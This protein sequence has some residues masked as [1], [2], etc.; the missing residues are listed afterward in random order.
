M[1]KKQIVAAAVR[2]ELWTQ[3]RVRDKLAHKGAH[4]ENKSP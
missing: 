2:R 3:R 4:K 1:G